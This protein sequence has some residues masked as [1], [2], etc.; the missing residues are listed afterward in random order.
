M[1]THKSTLK[2]AKELPSQHTTTRQQ[3]K[4]MNRQ[5]KGLQLTRV[6]QNWGRS[7]KYEH[8]NSNE[9]LY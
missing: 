9:H 5:K 7:A 4:E 3:K 2:N 8:W 1:P 6:L